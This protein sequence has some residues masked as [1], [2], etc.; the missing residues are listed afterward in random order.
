[1][2][3]M[4]VGSII[5]RFAGNT[6]L[7]PKDT[8]NAPAV[9][10]PAHTRQYWTFQFAGWSAM[11]LLSYLSLTVWYNPGEFAP[12]L[13][14]LLQSAL[15]IVVS[16][17]LRSVGKRLWQAPIATRI[18]LN[19][20]AVVTA[21]LVWSALRIQTFTWLTGEV[22]PAADYGGWIFASVIVFGAWSFCYHAFRYYRQSLEQRRLATEAQNAALRAQAKAQHESF[23]RLEAEKLFRDSQLRML[24]YQLN[25]HFFLNALNSVSS[26]V[27]KGDSDDAMRMLARIGDFL[28]LALADPEQVHQP[29]V[30]ELDALQTYLDIERVRFGDRLITEFDVSS[31]T[32]DVPVPCFLLQ[33]IF[34]NAVKHAV[35]VSLKPTTIRLRTRLDGDAL[36]IVV[37]DDGPGVPVSADTEYGGGR[38]DGGIGLLNVRQRLESAYG[39]GFVLSIANVRSESGLKVSIRIPAGR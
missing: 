36:E 1:M 10:T 12:A 30:D 26:L 29:L 32:L 38:G 6:N 4:G 5:C 18:A 21:S 28:R 16:H 23:K 22:I 14:T 25:P 3:P 39:E 19:A 17:P 34:E 9:T 11:A 7:M 15:G 33:P 2:A 37:T 31:D 24:K 8:P 20:L 13:H 27:R 35:G